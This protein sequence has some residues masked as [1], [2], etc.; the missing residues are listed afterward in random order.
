MSRGRRYDS[1]PKL[2]IKKVIAVFLVIAVLI[3]FIIAIRKLVFSDNTVTISAKNYFSVYLNDKWGVIDNNADIVIEPIYDEMIIIP[4][5]SKDLF[6]CTEN[7]DYENN[8]FNTKVIDSKNNEI[9]KTFEKIQAIENYDEY[10]NLWYEEDVLK[11][12]K[13]GK[14]GLISFSGKVILNAQYEKIYSLKGIKNALITVK[15]EKVGLVDTKGVEL[16]PNDYDEISSLGKDT[17]LYIVKNNNAYGIYNKLDAKYQEIKPLNSKNLYLVKENNKYKVIDEEENEKLNVK[18]DD[19]KSIKD[20]MIIYISNKKYGAYDVENNK[21]IK[22]Q[23]SDMFYA[24]E[25]NFVVKN[26]NSYG[27]IDI[28]GKNKIKIKYAG[29]N[30]YEDASIYELE[31]KN[32]T[33]GVNIILNKDLED[34]TRGIISD[35][36]V[37]K[38]YIKI[39]TEDGYKYYSLSGEEK[40]VT[41][42]LKENKIFLKKQNEKYGYVDKDG[43]VVVDFIYDDAKEQNKYGYAAIKKDGK[44]GSIDLSGKIICEPIYN[45]DDNLLIDF[46]G[47]YHLG[48]DINLMYYTENN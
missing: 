18:F 23:Y 40:A 4:D 16:I 33:S 32:N 25:N 36:V 17:N 35:V 31:P 37:E 46:I 12:E 10:N 20:N 8:T 21:T 3:A 9:L 41:D 13:D 48:R 45:L 7:V 14:I 42:I 38:S 11:Y 44:W 43:N 26:N 39:W 22:A 34:I 28:D 2:N 15:D 30:Y 27:I 47:K 1:E 19:I 29:I 24:S 6:I 5:N